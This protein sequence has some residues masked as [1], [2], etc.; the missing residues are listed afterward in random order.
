MGLT[1]RFLTVSVPVEIAA[2]TSSAGTMM[3]RIGRCAQGQMSQGD[4]GKVG[5]T[6]SSWG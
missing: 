5:P 1:G 6:I 4:C 3:E 2:S